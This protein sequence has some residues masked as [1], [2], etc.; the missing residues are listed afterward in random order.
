MR[1][2]IINKIF[3]PITKS[4]AE[5]QLLEMEI[6]EKFSSSVEGGVFFHFS[7]SH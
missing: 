7:L 3:V 6:F 2:E 4:V 5:S 1:N